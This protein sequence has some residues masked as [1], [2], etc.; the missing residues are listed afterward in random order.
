MK[1]LWLSLL[2]FLGGRVERIIGDEEKMQEFRV[3]EINDEGSEDDD[4]WGPRVIKPK[5]KNVKAKAKKP[6]MNEKEIQNVW[7]NEVYPAIKDGN[8]EKIKLWLD[9]GF[10]VEATAVIDV[11][12]L[13]Y[14]PLVQSVVHSQPNVLELLLMHGADPEIRTIW[15][16]SPLSIAVFI[17]SNQP[18]EPA[19]K[20][21]DLLLEYGVDIN[22]RVEDGWTA[23]FYAAR[24][25]NLH[26]IQYLLSKGADPS[27]LETFNS[28]APH[29]SNTIFRDYLDHALAR[30]NPT[31]PDCWPKKPDAENCKIVHE[32]T[33]EQILLRNLARNN[34]QLE[35]ATNKNNQS[36]HLTND[37][38]QVKYFPPP[39]LA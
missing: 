32:W 27:I 6:T 30:S 17:K 15:N 13:G 25:R 18:I 31:W 28:E 2:L 36:V 8:V 38:S 39:A 14:T 29:E 26:L 12:R 9:K 22:G 19:K 3:Y 33:K 5:G 20:I 24:I 23:L 4:G 37:S 11:R 35:N 1:A 34:S 16:T 10:D 21:I 7:T